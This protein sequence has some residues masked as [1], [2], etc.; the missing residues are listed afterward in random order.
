MMDCVKNVSS[1][2]II[3]DRFLF[4]NF[5]YYVFR[6]FEKMKCSICGADARYMVALDSTL[7][8]V[9]KQHVRKYAARCKKCLDKKE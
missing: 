2:K 6:R 4:L 3:Q 9:A 1:L 7:S 5:L 8:S